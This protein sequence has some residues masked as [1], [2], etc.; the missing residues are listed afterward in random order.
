M[1]K[2]RDKKVGCI[3]GTLDISVIR[4]ES[5]K[6]GNKEEFYTKCHKEPLF[7]SRDVIV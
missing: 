7:L 2:I 3:A 5:I 1:H 4:K 6:I